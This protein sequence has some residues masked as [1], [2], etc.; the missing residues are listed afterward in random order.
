MSDHEPFFGLSPTHMLMAT[1]GAAVFVAYLV[2]RIAFLRA[3][4]SS[5]ILMI[6][7]LVTFTFIPGM[8][9][10]LDPTVSPRIWEITSEI[11]VIVV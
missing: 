9:A 3:A 11:A 10:V 1:V 2:P 6:L 5:A 4:S 7:G 8:P